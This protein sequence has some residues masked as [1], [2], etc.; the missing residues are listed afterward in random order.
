[1]CVLKAFLKLL[2]PSASSK[3]QIKGSTS[4]AKRHAKFQLIPQTVKNR[5]PTGQKFLL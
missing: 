4:V 3:D 5:K 2:K 1:M